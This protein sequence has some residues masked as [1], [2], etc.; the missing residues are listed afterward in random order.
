MSLLQINLV[1]TIQY[2][3]SKNLTFIIISTLTSVF[4]ITYR[5]TK[6]LPVI[7][8]DRKILITSIT[9]RDRQSNVTPLVNCADIKKT[10]ERDK[11]RGISPGVYQQS[12]ES[13]PPLFGLIKLTSRQFRALFNEQANGNV[14]T[15]LI[16][17]TWCPPKSQRFVFHFSSNDGIIGGVTFREHAP[18]TKRYLLHIRGKMESKC[19][20]SC[21]WVRRVHILFA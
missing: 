11:K 10:S 19:H 5:G 12:A 14:P 3:E 15:R 13:N 2:G 6:D 21:A 16:N 18:S 4:F 20:C 8:T 1:S 9:V 17:S 7:T